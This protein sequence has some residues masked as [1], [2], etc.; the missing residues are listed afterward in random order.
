MLRRNLLLVGLAA[1]F[2]AAASLCYFLDVA[3]PRGGTAH[4][5]QPAIRPTNELAGS[6][7]PAHRSAQGE[8][9][10]AP[11]SQLPRG[12]ERK[13]RIEGEG[14]ET[15]SRDLSAA[16]EQLGFLE[17]AAER[18]GFLRGMFVAI[19]A[20]APREAIAAVKKVAH[21]DE[22][23]LAMETLAEA[24]RGGVPA[25]SSSFAPGE[26]AHASDAARLGL[27]LLNGTTGRAELALVW[28]E[29]LLTHPGERAAL[30]GA[31][32]AAFTLK[33]PD[34]VAAI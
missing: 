22:R 30:W 21:F 34:R 17:D 18:A 32:A 29:E 33:E 23:N 9:A 6:S 4:A 31:A 2:T 24:W 13:Q 7:S 15:A 27:S 14:Y 28:A 19:A 8:A 3:H 12:F 26:L 25:S 16:W 20:R 1:L 10:R 11:W 5:D